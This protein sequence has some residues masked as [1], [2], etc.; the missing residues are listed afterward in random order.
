MQ[1][2]SRPVEGLT[3]RRATAADTERIAEIIHGEP[4]QETVRMCGSV[5]RAR[6]LGYELVR[7]PRS[8]QGWDRS[9]VGELGGEVVVV[10]QAGKRIGGIKVTPKL[11][12]KAIRILGLF[13]AIGLLPKIRAQSRVNA[14]GPPD[15]YYISELHVHPQHRNR[16]I[17]S[18]ALDYAEAEARRLG[19]RHMS[20][21]TATTNPARRLYE[22]HGF[23]V[24]ETRTDPAFE[25]Y[26]GIAGRHLMVKALA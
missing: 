11:A 7:M 14:K 24:V 9:V 25:R 15:A 6:A 19:H 17:G 18:A 16:G 12:L 26:T 21:T 20:L 10:L 13:G 5:E 3:F 22:R 1:E 4:A 23:R 2:R 8:A